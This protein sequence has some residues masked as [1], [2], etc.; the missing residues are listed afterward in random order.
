MVGQG[1]NS[2]LGPLR[3]TEDPSGQIR[4][5]CVQ[6]ILFVGVIPEIKYMT[7]AEIIIIIKIN[8]FLFICGICNCIII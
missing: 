6:A 3:L 5:S 1:E 7:V 8:K 2:H 4:A